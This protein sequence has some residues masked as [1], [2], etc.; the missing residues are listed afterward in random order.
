M[1][2]KRRQ[3]VFRSQGKTSF[4]EE[5]LQ[6]LKGLLDENPALQPRVGLQLFYSKFE[7]VVDKDDNMSKAIKSKISN[8]K[9]SRKKIYLIK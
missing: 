9:Q 7:G 4:P 8:L 5:Y 6:F 3:E 1:L 2:L